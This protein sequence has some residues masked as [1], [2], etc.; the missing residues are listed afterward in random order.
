MTYKKKVWFSNR[1]VNAVEGVIVD[2][3]GNELRY[4]YGHWT[5]DI[6]SCSPET[7][8]RIMENP[9]LGKGPDSKLLVRAIPR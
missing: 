7:Y 1:D 2:K 9:S 3:N 8:R 5:S 6:W 4:I